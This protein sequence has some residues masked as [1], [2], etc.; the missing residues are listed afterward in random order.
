MILHFLYLAN[1][2]TW[3]WHF[4]QS[5]ATGVGRGDFTGFRAT[6]GNAGPRSGLKLLH[7]TLP[8]SK[9]LSTAIL[10]GVEVLRT[11][12]LG[13]RPSGVR[14]TRTMHHLDE[15]QRKILSGP[16]KIRLEGPFPDSTLRD[17]EELGDNKQVQ[18]CLLYTS[19]SPRDRQKSRMPS[20]A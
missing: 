1:R 15:E 2:S 3:S 5:R 13:A 12:P 19:P 14:D 16:T 9:R 10:A 20:S 4:G 7:C 18:V 8:L 17:N 6:L 11:K